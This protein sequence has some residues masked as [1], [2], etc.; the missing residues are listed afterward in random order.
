[1][2]KKKQQQFETK[3]D[4]MKNS[5]EIVKSNNSSN[6]SNRSNQSNQSNQSYTNNTS[7]I[8]REIKSK[9][10]EKIQNN[11]SDQKKYLID[12]KKKLKRNNATFTFNKGKNKKDKNKNENIVYYEEIDQQNMNSSNNNNKFCKEDDSLLINRDNFKNRIKLNEK[13]I[14]LFNNEILPNTNKYDIIYF[15]DNLKINEAYLK[16][17]EKLKPKVSRARVVDKSNVN[18]TRMIIKNIIGTILMLISFILTGYLIKNIFEKF[19]DNISKIVVIPIISS[20]LI[21]IFI[22]EIINIFIF[23]SLTWMAFE[24]KLFYFNQQL[25]KIIA[26]AINPKIKNIHKT[27]ELIA[28]MKQMSIIYPDRFNRKDGLK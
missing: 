17:L 10:S 12:Y 9:H 16:N 18:Y 7:N 11:L 3:D 22:I 8:N 4:D 6:Q 20:I 15:K 21:K 25:S 28:D 27:L 1:M 26:S 14:H 23:V 13:D 19:R 5:E 24:M 2:L